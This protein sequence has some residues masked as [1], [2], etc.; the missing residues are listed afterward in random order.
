[1]AFAHILL[2]LVHDEVG[3]TVGVILCGMAFG[4][5]WP[6]MVLSVGE[7]FGQRHLGANY[8]LY[9][10][11]CSAVGTIGLSKYVAQFFYERAIDKSK[12]T[13]MQGGE[14]CYGPECFRRSHVVIAAVSLSCVCTATLAMRQTRPLYKRI[15]RALD[16][17]QEPTP[18]RQQL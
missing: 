2:A 12:H 10:G 14:T 13:G 18:T 7:F 11:L 15:I 9:D 3:V 16:R 8:M 5:V 6:L 4:S 17:D 1:M